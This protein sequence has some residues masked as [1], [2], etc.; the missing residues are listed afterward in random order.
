[1]SEDKKK[2]NFF[3]LIMGGEV[4]Q[5]KFVLRQIP[6]LLLL[7]AYCVVLVANRYYVEYLSKEKISV[8]EEINYL[9]ETRIELEKR[10]QETIK[11]TAI[12]DNLVGSEVALTAGPPFEI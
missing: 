3:T 4:L 10:Y 8:Q 2:I 5:K 11:I 7:S 1:M 6:L 9:N 12:R